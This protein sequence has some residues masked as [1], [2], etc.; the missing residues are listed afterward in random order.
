MKTQQRLVS[1]METDVKDDHIKPPERSPGGSMEVP[2]SANK[3]KLKESNGTGGK[4]VVKG[5]AKPLYFWSS[6]DVNKWLRKHGGQCFDLYGEL[7]SEHDVTGRTL[8]RMN[9]IKLEKIGITSNDH[10]KDLMQ[11]ILRLRLKH[12][13]TDLKNLDQ[14]GSGFELKLP[15]P[16][17]QPEKHDKS[18]KLT[19][20]GIK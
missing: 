1:K 18:T 16:R 9:E 11:H 2:D 20:T 3:M 17:L 5:K 15:E 19:P 4:K 7:F 8:I 13:L 12:E 10:R 14:K 6:A